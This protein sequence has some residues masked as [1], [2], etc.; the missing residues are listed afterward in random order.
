MRCIAHRSMALPQEPADEHLPATRPFA[1][2][3]FSNDGVQP[4]LR[5][6][7]QPRLKPSVGRLR[8]VM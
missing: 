7:F 1:Q 3:G 5:F 6:S 4:T 2:Q 8:V